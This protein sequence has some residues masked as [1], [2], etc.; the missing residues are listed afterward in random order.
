MPEDHVILNGVNGA[1]GS[2]LMPE[3]TVKD[4]A[5]LAQGETLD[6]DRFAELKGRHESTAA[7]FGVA[8]GVD[9]QDLAQAGWGVLFAHDA[10]PELRAALAPL[11]TMR[12]EQSKDLY[13]E[14]SGPAGHRP[15]ESS[16]AWLARQGV[17]PGQ[18]QPRKVPYYLLVVG[19][20]ERIP[21][22][23]QYELGLN[24]SVGRIHF[25]TVDE[26]RQYAAGIV[27]AEGTSGA[28][29]GRRACLFGVRNAADQATTMSADH[30]VGPLA[31]AIESKHAAAGW[32]VD[33]LLATD[34]SRAN[35]RALLNGGEPPALLF[36]ASHGM[37]FPKSHALQPRHQGALLCQEWPGPLV[38]MGPIPPEFYFSAD[39]L[40]DS[41]RLSGMI[42]FHFAC[43]GAGT[44][45]LDDYAHR[46]GVREE[47]APQAFV[48]QLPRR[49]L[50]LPRGGALAAVGHVERA[51]GYSFTWPGAGDQTAVF[52]TCLGAL[53]D[54]SRLGPAMES[55]ALRHAD[56]AVSLNGELE[57][58]KFGAI[59]NEISL[60]NLWTANNDARSYVII[61]DPAVR[62]RV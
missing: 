60:A 46:G 20:P 17:G 3:L 1:T 29:V 2:Y 9:P 23:F 19:N 37:G 44:P 54:G 4:V 47:I 22:R 6:A 27:A 31:T 59:P 58:I 43:Y 52:E 40:T 57:D 21:F 49:M 8:Y 51:W 32:K 15:G 53:L 41:A 39:D 13:K 48:A 35:L 16:R 62:L 26:Y 30:L 12:A 33:R 38:H 34:A 24:Y 36:T 5:R 42:A 61:G 18:A 14:F 45:K 56:L 11:T 55:F 10:E 50:G 25:D 7:T 28:N